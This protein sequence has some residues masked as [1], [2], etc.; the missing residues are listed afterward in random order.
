M[1]KLKWISDEDLSKAVADL[2]ETAKNAKNNAAKNFGIN[3]IDP[4]SAVFE[5]AGFEMSYEEWIKSEQARQAQKTLQNFIGNFHQTILGFCKGWKNLHVGNIVDLVNEE[6]K[7]IAEIKNKY[8]T[9]SF[10]KLADSYWSLDSSVMPKTSIYKGYTAYHVSVI[11]KTSK[12]FDIEFTPSNNKTGQKCPSNKL[13]RQIDGAS[14]YTLATGD[15]NALKDLFEVIP[16]V[17]T[18]ITKSYKLDS[19]KLK[20]LFELAYG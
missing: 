16:S 15:E 4:F 14:F 20:K 13:I 11:P 17:I 10:G 1:P 5:M 9:V 12:R 8:N 2:L 7:I 6:K 19:I 3:V 18:N